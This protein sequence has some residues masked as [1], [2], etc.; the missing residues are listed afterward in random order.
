MV[1]LFLKGG[2]LMY[3]LLLLS[4]VSLA[5]IIER[6]IVVINARTSKKETAELSGAV[7][8]RKLEKVRELAETETSPVGAVLKKVFSAE[9][10]PRDEIEYE[11]SLSGSRIIKELSKNLHFLE[12]IGKIAPMLGLSGTILGLAQTFQTVSAVKGAA[13]PAILAGGIW[14]AMITTVTG[15]FI[16]IPAIIFYHLLSNRVKTISFHMKTVAEELIIALKGAKR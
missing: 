10:L 7:A 13:D 5:V 16:G 8:D 1:D 14:E 12:L 6:A 15:L 4:I 11:V 9:Q 2:I 3:P